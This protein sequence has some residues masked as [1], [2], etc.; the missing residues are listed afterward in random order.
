[1][2]RKICLT[3]IIKV[4][5]AEV[6][7]SFGEERIE[8]EMICASDLMSDVLSFSKSNALLITGLI[9]PQTVRTAE[10]VEISAICFVHGKQPQEETVKL[11]EKNEII[12]LLTKFSMF[13]ACGRLYLLGLT[14]CDEVPRLA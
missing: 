1:M 8:I 14:G 9:N 13:E 10:I 2:N 3:E 5:D 12:L 7:T 4:L 6:I 11:A